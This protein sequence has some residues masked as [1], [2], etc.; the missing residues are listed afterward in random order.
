MAIAPGDS[1]LMNDVG[2][3]CSELTPPDFVHAEEWYRKAI[4]TKKKSGGAAYN[5]GAEL[6]VDNLANL[7]EKQVRKNDLLQ[8]GNELQKNNDVRAPSILKR[9]AAL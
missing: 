4:A 5:S 8:L 9:A 1:M 2:I 3:A 7:L 6:A